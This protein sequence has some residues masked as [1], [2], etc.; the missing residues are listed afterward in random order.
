MGDRRTPDA[1]RW[2][3]GGAMYRLRRL[4]R[5]KCVFRAFMCLFIYMRGRCA[6]CVV[7][8]RS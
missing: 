2:G 3:G 7:C 4:R 6:S 5:S 8:V 1:P